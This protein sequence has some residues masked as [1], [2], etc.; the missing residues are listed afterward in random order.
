LMPKRRSCG[1]INSM[2]SLCKFITSATGSQAPTRMNRRAQRGFL[3]E[4]CGLLFKILRSTNLTKTHENACRKVLFPPC[5]TFSFGAM[6]DHGRR[7][8]E[9]M[10]KSKAHW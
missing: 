10:A 4:L 7:R 5:L 8:V 6:V 9:G 3:C 1:H 2:L